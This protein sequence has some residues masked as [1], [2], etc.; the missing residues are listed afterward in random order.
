M[1]D[2]DR[3]P[4]DDQLLQ[5]LLRGTSHCEA[6]AACGLSERTVRRRL[7]DPAFREELKGARHETLRHTADALAHAGLAAVHALAGLATDA[8]SPASVRRAAARDLLELSLRVREQVD[9]SERIEGLERT[10]RVGG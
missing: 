10:L 1:A 9:L 3:H 6:A 5:A 2:L 4:G 8:G 7:S